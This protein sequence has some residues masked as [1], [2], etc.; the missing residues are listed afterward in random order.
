M[1]FR[2]MAGAGRGPEPGRTGGAGGGGG[3]PAPLRRGGPRLF[4]GGG[5]PGLRLVERG[6]GRGPLVLAGGHR[7]GGEG[8]LRQV[9]LGEG[10]GSSASAGCRN[11]ST[12][13]GDGYDF[14]SRWRTALP[15]CGARR[16]WTA[17]WRSR[18]GPAGSCAAGRASAPAGREFRRRPRRPPDGDLP[19]D[20]GLPQKAE[21]PRR[22]L[23]PGG[24]GLFHPRG[25][26]GPGG[27]HRRLFQ[28]PLRLRAKI[29]ARAEELCGGSSPPWGSCEE[30]APKERRRRG[31]GREAGGG[32]PGEVLRAP[33]VP[34]GAAGTHLRRPGGAG[35]PGGDA[36]RG[37]EIPLLP[38][39]C[40]AAA[41]DG[42]GDLPPHLPDE[43]P[44]GG[45]HPGGDPCGLPQQL[46]HPGGAAP[47]RP[48][49]AGGGLPPPLRRAG[50]AGLPFR[51]LP[52]G[53]PLPWW[54]WTRPTASPSGGRTSAPATWR[55]P[56]SPPAFPGGPRW[57]PS[58]P[59]PPPG[60]GRTS[61]APGAAGAFLPGHRL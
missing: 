45:P 28:R 35:R 4:G 2:E 19:G 53:G 14:D 16:S 43:G 57:P 31:D 18:N 52:G 48:G 39:P 36:H 10:G 58:P 55:S 25:H 30:A 41:R 47:H 11:S 38:D 29:L 24:G 44:G 3:L 34:G 1:T 13:A 59:P 40:P 50:A 32:G 46:P 23:R 26:L 61:S 5:H 21:P 17:F 20:P 33:G 9:L 51:P 12:G 22:A 49:G 60:C 42:P 15:P 56:P 37:R 54:R 6:P 7:P 27:R 8:G